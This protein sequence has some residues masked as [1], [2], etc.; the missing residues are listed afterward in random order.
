MSRAYSSYISL[1]DL[2]T[3]IRDEEI[4]LYNCHCI[5]CEEHIAVLKS[6]RDR[7]DTDHMPIWFLQ[8]SGELW[9]KRHDISTNKL[10]LMDNEECPF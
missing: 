1:K 7:I 2:L 10:Y 3:F 6:I 5:P 9:N 8:P 4:R